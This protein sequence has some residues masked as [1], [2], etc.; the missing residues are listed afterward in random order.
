[1]SLGKG[2]S[3]ENQQKYIKQGKKITFLTKINH[4]F[5]FIDLEI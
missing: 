4:S 1:M 3:F 2:F 5:Q